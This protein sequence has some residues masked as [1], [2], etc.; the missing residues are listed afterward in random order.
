MDRP[1][2][3]RQGDTVSVLVTG[4]TGFVGRAVV[5]ALLV[6][7][8]D[9]H[10]LV[11]D[12]VRAAALGHA[13]VTLHP[14]DMLDAA[15]YRPLVGGMEAVV[16][17]AQ[18]AVGGRFTS[19]NARRIRDADHLMTGVLADACQESGARLVYT[20]GCF[21][22]GDRGDEWITETDPFRPSPLG[23]GHAAEVESLRRRHRDDGLDV[24]VVSPG[25]V[26][27]PGGLFVS[28]FYDQAVRGRLRVIGRGDNHWSAVHVEDL[29]RVYAAAVS[30]APSG[31]EYHA[32]DGAPL[33][34]RTL[35]D[36]LTDAMGSARVGTVPPAL[37]G[38]I[39]GRPLVDSLVTSF[40]MG[41]AHVRDELGWAPSH[42]T[43]ADGLPS[44]LASLDAR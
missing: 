3:C 22:H 35:V 26:Y 19:R 38:L 4:A 43:F 1:T 33:T 13:G 24:V 12:P 17:T 11:R 44:V 9:V 14:G 32:V 21:N 42:P 40:R 15:S 5:D 37:M 18:L 30:R 27:G 8:H 28:A 6:E 36:T 41:N 20:S 23:V 31:A 2:P 10:G 29:A 25:F 39:I 34:L 7:G 16:H